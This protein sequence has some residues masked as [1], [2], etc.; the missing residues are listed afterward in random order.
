MRCL[1]HFEMSTILKVIKFH[2]CDSPK[3]TEWDLYFM[4]SLTFLCVWCLFCCIYPAEPVRPIDPAAWISHTTAL[5]GPYP[6]YG[7]HNKSAP[8]SRTLNQSSSVVALWYWNKFS[9]FGVF[10]LFP[11]QNLMTCL[12]L[13]VK[14]TW[15]PSSKWCSCLTQAWRSETGCG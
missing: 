4:M 11:F 1:P 6:H 2:Y 8:A 10:P 5:T 3:V 12:C 14:Q 15:Q 9:F 13:R 7:R